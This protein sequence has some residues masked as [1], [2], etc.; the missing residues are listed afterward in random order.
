MSSSRTSSPWSPIKR[1]SVC[2]RS[3]LCKVSSHRWKDS[4]CQWS[5]NSLPA[6]PPKADNVLERQFLI[7]VKWLTWN[8]FSMT[9]CFQEV[10]P[11]CTINLLLMTRFINSITVHIILQRTRQMLHR[12]RPS[13]CEDRWKMIWKLVHSAKL[14]IN[15]SKE[16]VRCGWSRVE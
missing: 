3:R 7:C 9:K 15:V 5:S 1:L 11:K 6:R 16:K 14:Q 12:R 10:K 2:G 4:G 8:L 13:H